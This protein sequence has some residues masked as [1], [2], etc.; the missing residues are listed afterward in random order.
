MYREFK[1][2]QG[3]DTSTSKQDK[4]TEESLL[5]SHSEGKGKGKEP[6]LSTPL[7]AL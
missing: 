2:G 3:E 1:K 6:P 4:G 5:D 7:L